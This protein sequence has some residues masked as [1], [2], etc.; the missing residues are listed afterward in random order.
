MGILDNQKSCAIVIVTHNSSSS[1]Y[2][3]L[4]PL[5]AISGLEI[6]V[7][8]NKSQDGCAMMVERN[9]TT[10]KVICS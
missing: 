9:F 10:I 8:D 3:C 5:V 7:V 4:G 1:I 2:D 6:I